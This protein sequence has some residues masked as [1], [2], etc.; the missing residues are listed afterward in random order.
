M[1]GG[2][3]KLFQHPEV[4]EGEGFLAAVSRVYGE[5]KRKQHSAPLQ[6]TVRKWEHK[7]EPD[8]ESQPEPKNERVVKSSKAA[9]GSARSIEELMA[10]YPEEHGRILTIAYLLGYEKARDYGKGKKQSQH[11]SDM[12]YAR[13]ALG[14]LCRAVRVLVDDPT[15]DVLDNVELVLAIGEA[16]Y[17]KSA[18]VAK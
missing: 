18:E 8:P 3:G 4:Q 11:D 6:V 5:E 12:W 13:Q 1:F 10:M 15:R 16:A 9:P 17:E 2:L 14:Q 7:P